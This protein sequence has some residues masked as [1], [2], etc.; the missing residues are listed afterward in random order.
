MEK[1]RSDQHKCERIERM[2]LFLKCQGRQGSLEEVDRAG[3][4]HDSKIPCQCQKQVAGRFWAETLKP[5][6]LVRGFNG[7]GKGACMQA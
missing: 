2:Q 5:R 1:N 6:P 7:A 3:T 4:V